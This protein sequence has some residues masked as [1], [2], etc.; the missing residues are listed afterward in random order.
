VYKPV[1]GSLVKK[2]VVRRRRRG[3]L[4]IA[5][6]FLVAVQVSINTFISRVPTDN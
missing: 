5:D 3:R 1:Y 4:T 2:K 6:R